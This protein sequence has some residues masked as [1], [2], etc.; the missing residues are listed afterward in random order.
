MPTQK[1]RYAVV[2]LGYISQAAVLPAFKHAQANSVLAALVSDDAVKLQTLGDKYDVKLRF[3]YDQYDDLLCSG[4]ID[5]VYIALPNSLHREY[6]VRAAE[7]GIHVLVEKPMAV[8]EEDC[9]AMIY[10]A[11]KHHVKLMVAYRLHFEPAN[12]EAI[13]LVLNGKIGEPRFF[14]ASF[15][16]QVKEGDIRVNP[17][18][19][20]GSLLDMGIYCI[21]AA[22]YIFQTE[23]TE[24]TAFSAN[25]GEVR[26]R[27]VDEMTV[28]L[29]RFPEDRLASFVSSM[30]SADTSFFRIVGTRGDIVL[31]PA[32]DFATG[33][34]YILTVN[35]KKTARRFGKMDQFAPELLYF[36]ECIATG[37]QPEPSGDEGL[38]D[39]R[40]IEALY[41]SAVS[42]QPVALTNY[43]TKQ[44]PTIHQEIRRPPIRRM[45]DLI[46]AAPPSGA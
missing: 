6:A 29:L 36:S 9:Q 24:V 17:N 4:E 25:N 21:N 23:P 12:L 13:D 7:A 45:P 27:G 38:A 5:A 35:G 8:T 40:I 20:G 34:Q 14:V 1:T 26:F 19:G 3:T 41:R 32:F 43:E 22:R 10:A 42:H 46:H 30:G 37:Q 18:L 2:G 16:Q 31:E 15:S 33:L 28:G 39:V 44:R 11:Q